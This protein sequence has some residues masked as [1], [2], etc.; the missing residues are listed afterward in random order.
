MSDL[1]N[2]NAPESKNN[3]EYFVLN[4][5]TLHYTVLYPCRL[6][7]SPLWRPLAPDM[8]AMAMARL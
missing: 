4:S 7:C 5:I 2:K 6:S 3:S 8:S 1:I